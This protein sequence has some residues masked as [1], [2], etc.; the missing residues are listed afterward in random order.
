MNKVL[1]HNF[2][3]DYPATEWKINKVCF[4]FFWST[5]IASSVIDGRPIP[6]PTGIA[7]YIDLSFLLSNYTSYF[8]TLLGIVFSVLYIMEK[9]M[10]PVTFLM[11]ILSLV[12][13]TLEDSNGVL[14]RTSLY[15]MIFLVQWIAYMKN[16]PRLPSERIQYAVQ[17]IAAGY[18]LA[19][20]SKLSASGLGWIS[21]SPMASLQ[22]LKGFAYSYF[23]S[24]NPGDMSAGINRANFI[25]VHPA[26]TRMLFA[27]SLFA[28]L[29]AWIAIKNKFNAFMYGIL[30]TFMH[31][32]IFYLMNIL[33]TAI[34]YPMLIFMVNPGYLLYCA[35]IKYAKPHLNLRRTQSQ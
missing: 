22:V 30:L 4:C 18:V 3:S 20:I 2:F 29:F 34:F 35:Y 5:Q 33:I 7:S 10:R 27:F 12:V 17:I 25:L 32:G 28:E 23:D 21:S 14:N 16:G 31:L 24:G 19:A 1:N 13:F 15:T 26:V 9:W 6:Y 11:F 8:F